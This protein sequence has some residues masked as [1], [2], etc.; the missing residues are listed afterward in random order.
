MNAIP[1]VAVAAI[2]IGQF[3]AAQI[4]PAYDALIGSTLPNA[5]GESIQ[6]LRLGVFNPAKQAN[7]AHTGWVRVDWADGSQDGDADS[8][9]QSSVGQLTDAGRTALAAGDSAG[10]ARQFTAALRQA[11][12]DPALLNNLATARAML[13]DI[14]GALEL[15]RRAV[16]LAPGRD[17]IRANLRILSEWNRRRTPISTD[18]GNENTVGGGSPGRGEGSDVGSGLSGTPDKRRDAGTRS[19]GRQGEG[20]TGGAQIGVTSVVQPW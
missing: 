4:T 1:R 7:R 14:G 3:A 20:E 18:G 2:F 19:Q 17:D 9:S 6:M 11:P 15:L 5:S 13:G 10:A 12:D 8:T 16:T